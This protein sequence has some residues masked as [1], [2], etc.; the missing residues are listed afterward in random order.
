MDLFSTSVPKIW[1]LPLE[2]EAGRWDI[3]GVFNWDETGRQ[4][5][6]LDFSALGLQ[7]TGYYTVYD[8]WQDRYYGTA[9]GYLYIAV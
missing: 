9:Q 6:R 7:D 8:Y 1:L 2:S 4:R 3:V 5:T